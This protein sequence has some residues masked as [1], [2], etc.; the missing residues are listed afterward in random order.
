[1]NSKPRIP[2]LYGQPKIHKPGEAMRPIVSNIHSALQ[3]LAKWLVPE[4][5]KL[6][7]V[8]GQYVKNSVDLYQKLGQQTITE[9][10]IL[11]SFDV[12]SLFPS[13]PI[14]FALQF[15]NDWLLSLNL[16]DKKRSAFMEIVESCLPL[17]SK[18]TSSH[19]VS[20]C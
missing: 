2:D 14:Y 19:L 5:K 9:D 17:N 1:M 7:P 13:I 6:P 15:M 12:V 11:V 10:E 3:P 20:L 16:E 8:K 4:F 18:P